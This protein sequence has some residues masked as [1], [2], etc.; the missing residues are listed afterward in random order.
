MAWYL[1]LKGMVRGCSMAADARKSAP[2]RSKS[3]LDGGGQ[4]AEKP[5]G[6]AGVVGENDALNL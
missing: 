1:I 2:R 6:Q 4:P 5:P 3:G